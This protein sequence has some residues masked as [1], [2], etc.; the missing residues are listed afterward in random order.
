LKSV[1]LK[2]RGKTPQALCKQ[3]IEAVQEFTGSSDL[4]DDI[5]LVIFKRGKNG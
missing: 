5:T 1:V 2:N 4:A 3:V